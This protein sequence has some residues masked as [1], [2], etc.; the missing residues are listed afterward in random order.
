MA[1]GSN[2][3]HGLLNMVEIVKEYRDLSDSIKILG[4]PN[5]GIPEDHNGS[6]VYTE[7]AD[8][9]KQHINE[10]LALEPSF[11]GGCCG[12]GPNHI[13]VMREAINKIG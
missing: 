11:I 2:C 3:G 10:M 8:F 9:F 4:K 7:D 1:V 6:I 13:K 12:T 5:A